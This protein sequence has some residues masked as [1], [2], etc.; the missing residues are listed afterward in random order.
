M[1]F[2]RHAPMNDGV[3]RVLGLVAACLAYLAAA[4]I[5]NQGAA[6]LV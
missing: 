1:R 4:P 2:P 3:L 6:V 5:L